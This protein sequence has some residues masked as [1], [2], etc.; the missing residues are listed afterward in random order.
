MYQAE[1]SNPVLYL[2]SF[3]QVNDSF[4]NYE[5]PCFGVTA[6]FDNHTLVLAFSGGCALYA[7]AS[8]PD[9]TGVWKHWR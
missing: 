9:E 5:L 3:G 8:E 6:S 2:P 7:P 4:E 1:Y